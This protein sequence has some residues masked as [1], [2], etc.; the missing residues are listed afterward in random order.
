VKP[1]KRQY[2]WNMEN[3]PQGIYFYKVDIGDGSVYSG[4]I[5]KQ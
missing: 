1:F 3:V 4:K 5:V 2:V